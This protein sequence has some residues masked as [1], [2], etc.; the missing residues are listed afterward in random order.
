MKLYVN[1]ITSGAGLRRDIKEL[2]PE[3]NLRRRMSRVVKS[4][5]AAG[6]ESLLEFGDRAA[7]EAVVTATGLGCIADSE[8]FLDSLIANEERMLNP[9]PFIQSTF[10]TVGA[11]IALLRG[12][13]CYNTTYA[14][15]WTS[16]EN[17]LTDAA[18]RIGAG[19][20]RAVLVGAFDET[21]PSAGI[22]LQRLGVAQQ[23]G[24]GESSIFFVL[25]AEAFDTSV[26]A[27]TG[28]RFPDGTAIGESA[29]TG[30]IQSRENADTGTSAGGN[31][32]TG[33]AAG[34]VEEPGNATQSGECRTIRASMSGVTPHFTAIAEVFRRVVAGEAGNTGKA[35]NIGNTGNIEDT[36]NAGQ[37]IVLYNDFPGSTVS[38]IELTCM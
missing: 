8:K 7:V 9:T 21:T 34:N 26:A 25:T 1:C 18:L 29:G 3:M 37:R 32:G 17:A 10:N 36:G 24:W 12:L 11:Q 27:I 31:A 6:I 22:I 13:H 23:G 15:R 30:R 33:A 2:I 5:V 28:I 16:F 38:A 4:G 14:N 19:L 20:S 35:G